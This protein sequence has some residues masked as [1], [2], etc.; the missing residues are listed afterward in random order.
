MTFLG[1]NLLV[2]TGGMAPTRPGPGG[3]TA[4]RNRPP[5]SLLL[6]LDQVDPFCLWGKKELG[7]WVIGTGTFNL[8][9]HKASSVP[10]VNHCRRGDDSSPSPWR[11]F[12]CWKGCRRPDEGEV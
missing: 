7:L 4:Q 8:P 10:H 6:L 2:P 1:E 3:G 5:P 11:H 12:P 9:I